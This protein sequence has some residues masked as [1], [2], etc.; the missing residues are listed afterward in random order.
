MININPTLWGP[1]LWKFMH[2]LTLSYPEQPSE[3]DV[4]KFKNFFM[5]IGEYLPCE[6]CRYN[7]KDHLQVLPLTEN[8]LSCRD[9][10]ILWLFNLHNIV[11]KHIGKKEFTI[12]EFN[13]VYVNNIN[14]NM[15]TT[16]NKNNI[17]SNIILFIILIIIVVGLVLYKKCKKYI[18]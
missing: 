4:N 13:D 16:T 6:K 15:H 2:Y 8:E 9:N 5:N 17:L 3:Y 10:L 12:K 11:N 18:N 7:Y 1:N 14:A